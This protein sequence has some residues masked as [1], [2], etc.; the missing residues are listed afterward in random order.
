[1]Y[2]FTKYIVTTEDYDGKRRK[3]QLME[4]C[5]RSVDIR[6]GKP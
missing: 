4:A 5:K 2:N 6:N 1:M 3:K